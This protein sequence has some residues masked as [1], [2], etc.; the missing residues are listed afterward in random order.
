[1]TEYAP[2]EL[3]A[4]VEKALHEFFSKDKELLCIDANERSI[5]HKLAEHLQRQFADLDVDCE[6]NR[7]DYKVK[8]PPNEEGIETTYSSK[9]DTVYPDI[10]VHKRASQLDNKIVIEVKKSNN[11]RNVSSDKARLRKFT[12]AGYRYE[13]NLGLFL[14]FGV[15]KQSGLKRS[16]CYQSG[17][18][19]PS[20]C[21]P[22]KK[23]L[24][25]F[26]PS[27]ISTTIASQS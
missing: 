3:H 11:K 4:K 5:T 10:V 13:Y 8:R 26:K 9:R 6:Y 24:N 25:S 2:A 16:E 18:K 20:P 15:R 27:A 12:N 19:T 21:P 7:Y 17:K 1:M 22:C 14:E 23:L